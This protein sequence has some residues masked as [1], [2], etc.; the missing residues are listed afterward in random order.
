MVTL[1]YYENEGLIESRRSA[2]SGYREFSAEMVQRVRQLQRFRA[3][4]LTIQEMRQMLDWSN[5]PQERCG[6]TC[7]LIERHLQEV[8]ERKAILLEL[9]SELQRLLDRCSGSP[10]A[11]CGIL[12]DFSESV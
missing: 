3:L 6:D 2:S 7:R 12:R 4:N 9:E 10:A 5:S 1:R 8:G 11:E